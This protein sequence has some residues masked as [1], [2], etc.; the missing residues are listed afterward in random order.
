M[1]TIETD[2][3]ARLTGLQTTSQLYVGLILISIPLFFWASPIMTLLW[4]L[5]ASGV[6][7]LGHASLMEKGGF[8]SSSLHVR[9]L[10]TPSDVAASFSEEAV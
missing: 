3:S 2:V 8:K 4:L 7:I 6:A 5:G 10:T 9:V 1:W